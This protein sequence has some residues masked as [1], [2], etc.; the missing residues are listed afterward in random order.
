MLN[1][2]DLVDY[3]TINKNTSKDSNSKNDHLREYTSKQIFK[4]KEGLLNTR[5]SSSK[6]GKMSVDQN[7]VSE[8]SV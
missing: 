4:D 3:S 6:N 7:K 5:L 2:A 1:T 8:F